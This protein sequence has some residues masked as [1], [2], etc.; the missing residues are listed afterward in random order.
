ML[1]LIRHALSMRRTQSVATFASV[2]ISVAVVLALAL[3]FAG[4]QGG[5][6]KSAQ[7]LGAD[8]MV[9]PADAAVNLDENALL[10]TGAPANMYMDSSVADDVAAVAGVERVTA[11]F[12]GQTLDASC[13]SA[14]EPARL[15]GYDAATDWV[16]A[17]WADR[18]VEGT[19]PDGQVVVGADLADDYAGGGRVL[20]H[21]VQVA[22]V[23]DETGTDLDGSILMSLDQV[24][25]FVSDTPELA[26]L[27]G[28]YGDPSGLVSCV[29]VDAADGQEDAVAAELSAMEGISVVRGSQAVERVASQMGGLFAVMAGAAALLVAATLFQLFARFFSLAWDR[30][31]ELALYRAL[32]ASKREVALLIGGEAAILVGGGAVCGIVAGIGLYLAV[33]GLLA[34]A[35]SFPFVNPPVWVW[36]ASIAGALALFVVLGAAAV[37]LPLARAGRI[38]PVAAMQTGDID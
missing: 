9:I 12:Y 17:P 3:S 23:L 32:G 28:E 27:W 31:S 18:L 22:A 10:F 8:L 19:L 38:D 2:L 35:G 37:A 30:R 16:V 4:V 15:I 21:E 6:Q 34:G 24:R 5:L 26:Y 11:Q 33:P 7:R 13:C 25:A 1:T 29:L 36:V 20:G 14:S